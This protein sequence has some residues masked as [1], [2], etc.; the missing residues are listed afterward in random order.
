MR[1]PL[2][3]APAHEK[4]DAHDEGKAQQLHDGPH[5]SKGFAAGS[6]TKLPSGA[7]EVRLLPDPYRWYGEIRDTDRDQVVASSWAG[8]WTAYAS[9]EEASRAGR[10][11][12]GRPAA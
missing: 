12:L 4:A 1:A 10:R 11:R 3:G 8:E 9:P 6:G 7:C 2:V 5:A